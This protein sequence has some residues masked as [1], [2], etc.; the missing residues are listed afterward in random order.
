MTRGQVPDAKAAAMHAV[1]QILVPIDFSDV[2]RAALES[3]RTLADACGAS[4]HL[5]HVLGDPLAPPDV[6]GREQQDA[7]VRLA[8]LL[9]ERDRTT[10]GATASCVPGTP[11]AE[12]V[13]YAAEHTI[14]VIVMGTHAHGPS[15]R[16]AAGSIADA[17][18]GL[19]PCAVLAVKAPHAVAAGDFDPE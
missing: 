9:D 10:R 17:V 18:L 6:L 8:A 7:C 11:A 13:R 2:S 19:A 1:K 5:I 4:L 16:M 12:I 14:D 15:F 3:A